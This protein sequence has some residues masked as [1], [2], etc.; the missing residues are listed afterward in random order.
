MS[1]CMARLEV[2]RYAFMS[3]AT[4]KKPAW[5]A[6]TSGSSRDLTCILAAAGEWLWGRPRYDGMPLIHNPCRD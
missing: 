2:Y 5:S 6:T 4:L 3:P 1:E